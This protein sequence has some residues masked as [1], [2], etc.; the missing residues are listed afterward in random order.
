MI[1]RHWQQAIDFGFNAVMLQPCWIRL[2]LDILT[3]TDI[4]IAAAI[5]YPRNKF[6]GYKMPIGVEPDIGIFGYIRKLVK[7]KNE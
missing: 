5:C 2:A 6:D 3:G 1:K 7:P 4:R